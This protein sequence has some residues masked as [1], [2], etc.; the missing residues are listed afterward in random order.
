MTMESQEY[1]HKVSIVN[2]ELSFNSS[3]EETILESLLKAGFG[4]PYECNASGCGSCKFTVI[5]GLIAEDVEK[6]L[7]LTSSDLRKNRKLACISRAKSDC[8]ISL[9][10]DTAYESSIRPQRVN[11]KLVSRESLTPDLWEFKLKS[12]SPAEFLPGQYAKLHIPK[13][14][15]PRNYSMANTANADGQWVFQIKRVPDGEATTILF[16]SDLSGM[17]ITIDGPY[18]TAYLDKQSPRSVVCIAGG[19]GL[20][21]MASVIRGIAEWKGVAD[22]VILYYGARTVDDVIDSELFSDINGFIPDV[23]Y[24]PVISQPEFNSEWKGATG[25]IHEHLAEVLPANCDHLDFY[26]AGPPP[27]VDAVRRLLILDRK[28]PVEQLRYDRFF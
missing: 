23:Q 6:P 4:M 24:I 22:K 7:G 21:P 8:T 13:V 3:E 1:L 17:N 5:D 26:M 14:S 18:S 15:G 16:D 20:A 10:L 27:M 28:V 25:F 11:A 19:S 12:E 9:K 2:T